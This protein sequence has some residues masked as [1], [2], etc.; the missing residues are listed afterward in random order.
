M[1][2]TGAPGQTGRPASP[3]PLTNTAGGKLVLDAKGSF[4]YRMPDGSFQPI[5]GGR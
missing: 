1:P 4:A 2:P 5:A 3:P